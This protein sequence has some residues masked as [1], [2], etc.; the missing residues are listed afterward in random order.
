MKTIQDKISEIFDKYI[1]QINTPLIRKK[2]FEELNFEIFSKINAKII[3]LRPD[4]LDG[5]IYSQILYN[6]NKIYDLN[7]FENIYLRAIR[8]EKLKKINKVRQNIERKNK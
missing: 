5:I 3:D 7:E 6:N 8:K 1:G 2:I 4:N